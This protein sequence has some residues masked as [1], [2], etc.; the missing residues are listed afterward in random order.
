MPAGPV[1]V[2]FASLRERVVL[3]GDEAVELSVVVGTD[4]YVAAYDPTGGWELRPP[5]GAIPGARLLL[6]NRALVLVAPEA[7]GFEP[8]GARV[9][10]TAGEFPFGTS[11]V[12]PSPPLTIAAGAAGPAGTTT[13]TTDSGT[14]TTAVPVEDI[15]GF[16]GDFVAAYAASED[17]FL[18]DRLH[19]VV[20]DRYGGE[21]CAV[22]IGDSFAPSGLRLVAIRSV[23]PEPFDY[24][25]DGLTRVVPDAVTV[26]VTLEDSSGTTEQTF[27]FAPADGRY[28]IFIDCG[29]PLP[30]AP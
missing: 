29:T 28:R 19:P 27:H 24:A 15:E 21:A 11:L 6:R 26:V 22:F 7:A 20:I 30:G 3:G 18:L 5:G 10:G 25:S 9:A 23:T 12:L 17:T 1:A 13:T 4:E 8:A 16:V 2:A 14:T